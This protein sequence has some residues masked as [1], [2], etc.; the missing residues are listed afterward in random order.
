MCV[1]IYIY[2]THTYKTCI[3]N[4]MY[5]YVYTSCIIYIYTHVYVCM[6]VYLSLSLY[7][8]TFVVLPRHPFLAFRFLSRYINKLPINRPCR[9][10]LVY[11]YIYMNMCQVT[12]RRVLSILTLGCYF[13]TKV[14]KHVS[15]TKA[16]ICNQV[17]ILPISFI[18]STHIFPGFEGM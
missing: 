5:I 11:I 12:L 10:I 17:E 14:M 8:Y 18:S 6:C 15:V 3:Y 16:A 1:Y 13:M 7:I 9:Q 4:I 2:H